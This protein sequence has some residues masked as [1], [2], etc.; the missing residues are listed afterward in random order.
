MRKK[1]PVTIITRH[2]AINNPIPGSDMLN[3]GYTVQNKG[4]EITL[5]STK[6]LMSQINMLHALKLLKNN[7]KFSFRF[8]QNTE[9]TLHYLNRGSHLE[10]YSYIWTLLKDVFLLDH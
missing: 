8:G 7:P 1:I 3:S 2:N 5:Y 10:Q 4:N 6:R 9:K